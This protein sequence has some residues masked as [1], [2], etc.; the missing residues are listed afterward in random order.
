MQKMNGEAAT[1]LTSPL[2]SST[3]HGAEANTGVGI[4]GIDRGDGEDCSAT[5]VMHVTHSRVIVTATLNMGTHRAAQ[6][7]LERRRGNPAGWAVV[8]GGSFGDE[9]PWI[10]AELAR[11]ATH[12]PFPYEVANMLPSRK[13]RKAAVELAAKEVARG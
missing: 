13:A 1:T 2:D 10:S 5:L 12:L 6:R 7:V 11:L 3:G 9:A 4:V 8:K